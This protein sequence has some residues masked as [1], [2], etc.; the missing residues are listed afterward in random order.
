MDTVPANWELTAAGNG[1]IATPTIAD[2][3]M[4]F[5][6]QGGGWPSAVYRLA[7]GDR[8]DIPQD[9]WEDLYIHFN[10]EVVAGAAFEL[11]IGEGRDADTI[12]ITRI[13]E[14]NDSQRDPGSFDLTARTYTGRVSLATALASRY[15]VENEPEIHTVDTPFEGASFDFGG[16]RVTA[17]NGNVIVR[18][19]RIAPLAAGETGSTPPPSTATPTPGA[20]TGTPAPT[21]TPGPNPPTADPGITMT[22]MAGLAGLAGAGLL[23]GKKKK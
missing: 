13:F 5:T 6:N 7:A 11:L 16:L 23:I 19:F 17:V 1:T 22:V 15:F 18:E 14:P 8:V 10:V 12:R 4:T 21:G 9:E 3:V 20:A 2:G